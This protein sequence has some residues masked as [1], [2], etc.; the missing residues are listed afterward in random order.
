MVIKK[1][2]KKKQIKFDFAGIVITIGIDIHLRQWNV[3]IYIENRHHK[4]FQQDP[5]PETLFRYLQKEFPGANYQSSYEAGYFGYSVHRKLVELGIKNIVVNAADIPTSD[6]EK[7][8]KNDRV[9]AKKIGRAQ[10]NG[11]TKGIYIPSKQMEADRKLLRYRTTV[12]R[13]SITRNKQRLKAYLV[14]LGLHKKIDNYDKSYWSKKLIQQ[15]R[16]LE[17]DQLSDKF[18]LD[19][20]LDKFDYLKLKMRKINR[21][22]VLLSRHPRYEKIVENLKSV[23]G[24]G[25]LTAMALVTEIWDMERF[26][27][28]DK[29][30]S[31]VGIVPDTS[32]SDT[33]EKVKGI[34]KRANTELR[35]LLVQASWVASGRCKYL[36]SIYQKNKKIR[37]QKA[38]IKVSRKL[39]SIIRAVWMKGEKYSIEK[40]YVA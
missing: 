26:K 28:L 9:D 23:P 6:K 13:K 36:G 39:L 35:R 2:W 12:I 30:S 14:R 11:L 19:E 25:L 33:K 1:N 22:I 4:T 8:R 20:L 40:M 32:S 34:T 38:I 24:I 37:Q 16:D 21:Q 18:V 3:S 27:S 29:L 17:I 31:F 15:I 7:R 5:C 10:L